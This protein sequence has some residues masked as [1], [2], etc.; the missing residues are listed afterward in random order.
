MKFKHDATA[1][2]DRSLR[3]PVFPG[4]VSDGQIPRGDSAAQPAGGAGSS[5]TRYR[6]RFLGGVLGRGVFLGALP[7]AKAAGLFMTHHAPMGAWSSL[8][9]GL[10]GAG[11]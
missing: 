7:A 11:V 1:C 8:T 9:F 2:R 4:N 3:T 10:P 5:D 6:L